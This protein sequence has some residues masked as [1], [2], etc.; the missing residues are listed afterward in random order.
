MIGQKDGAPEKNGFGLNDLIFVSNY[1]VIN[2]TL[3]NARIKHTNQ[4][5]CGLGLRN[6]AD[7]LI[8]KNG[9]G[10]KFLVFY[11]YIQLIN[12]H[13]VLFFTNSN[14]FQILMWVF[15]LL[16]ARFLT[17]FTLE[18]AETHLL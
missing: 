17:E 7:Y 2:F 5:Q 13:F 4:R 14:R 15:Q 8:Q 11:D 12:E 1:L 16:V 10:D 9:L 18:E 6:I 3:K